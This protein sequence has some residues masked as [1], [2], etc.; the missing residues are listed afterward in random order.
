MASPP[1]RS[2]VTTFMLRSRD[3]GSLALSV[4]DKRH[5]LSR[6][7]CCEP[8]DGPRAGLEP[9]QVVRGGVLRRRHAGFADL[10]DGVVG[11]A[12]IT[13]TLGGMRAMEELARPR[14]TQFIGRKP[15]RG[16]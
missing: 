4:G 11:G 15:R 12:I 13:E 5:A 10:G 9:R 1:E 14:S 3:A 7:F 2:P 16:A 6:E 8:A